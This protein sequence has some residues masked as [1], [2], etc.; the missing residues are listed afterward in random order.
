MF[1]SIVR[2]FLITVVTSMSLSANDASRDANKT[3]VLECPLMKPA[4]LKTL[5]DAGEIQLKGKS[6]RLVFEQVTGDNY[7]KRL[8]G[9]QSDLAA[10]LNKPTPTLTVTR[11]INT[12]H[13]A[14]MKELSKKHCPYILER[15]SEI[16]VVAIAPTS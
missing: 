2:A 11:Y 4:D 12:H 16:A 5:A 14:M 3:S 15:G 1:T 8:I 13:N 6:F 9:S 10:F 7:N